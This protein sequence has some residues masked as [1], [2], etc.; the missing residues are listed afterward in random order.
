MR[1]IDIITW[2]LWLVLIILVTIYPDADYLHVLF[3][4]VIF[5]FT[6]ADAVFVTFMDLDKP[7]KDNIH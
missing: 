3:F 1:V 6:L 5:P 2:L 4:A 7:W